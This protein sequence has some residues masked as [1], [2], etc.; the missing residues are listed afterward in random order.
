MSPVRNVKYT[1]GEIKEAEVDLDEDKDCSSGINVST[2]EF[3][4]EIIGE[5]EWGRG[6]DFGNCLLAHA[7]V[8]TNLRGD[9][10]CIPENS[11]GKIRVARAR[12]SENPLKWK[13]AVPHIKISE[14][15]YKF[16]RTVKEELSEDEM[17][18][19]AERVAQDSL[20]SYR[21]GCDWSG[22]RF[23]QVG[24]KLAEKVAQDSKWSYLAGRDWGDDRFEPVAEMLAEKVA[25]DSRWSYGAG[26]D[27]KDERKE[28]LKSVIS[29]H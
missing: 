8:P 16:G 22:E 21:A 1:P 17:K 28:V 19:I 20:Y 27:W 13:L 26:C 10:Y 6:L 4:V 15:A 14:T 11:E 23:E 5:G 9:E 2:L 7:F 12:I 3:I 29:G 18:V 25:Q 24:G